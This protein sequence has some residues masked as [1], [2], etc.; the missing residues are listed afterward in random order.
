[1]T[2]T[3]RLLL[4]V[5]A[6]SGV[7]GLIFEVA[8]QR[9]L[10][11][12]FGVTAW[13]SATVLAAFMIG[14]T[15]GAVAVGNW[16]D[17][18]SNP[19]GLYAALEGG[20]GVVALVT[21]SAS[22][23]LIQ[24]FENL[25]SGR[26][27]SSIYVAGIRLLLALAF[28]LIPAFMMG[29]TF[30]ALASGIA[31]LVGNTGESG[32]RVAETYAANL[33]GAFLGAASATYLLLPSL[34]LSRTLWCGAALNFLAGAAALLFTRHATF[35][36]ATCREIRRAPG[37]FLAASAWSGF[38]TF[39]YEVAWTQLVAL[40]I[41][42]SAY[43]FGSMLASFLLG[44]TAGSILASRWREKTPSWVTIGV[45][46]LASSIAVVATLPLW[47]NAPV[48]FARIGPSI[49]GF[50]GREAVRV[51]VCL[52]VLCA[53]SIVLGM[54][55][56]VLLRGTAGESR[57][58]NTLGGMTAINTLGAA[59]GSLS[60]G[61][62]FLPV[63]GSRTLLELIS[64]AGC[65]VAVLCFRRQTRYQIAALAVAAAIF[66]VPSWD[67]IKI[68]SGANVYFSLPSWT[69][70]RILFA[71]ESVESGLTT[72][73]ELAPTGSGRKTLLTN[74]KFQGN[75]SGEIIAQAR[76]AQLPLLVDHNYQRALLIGI[77][78]ATSLAALA[79]EPYE[80]VEAAD[81]SRDIVDAARLHFADLNHHV[82]D[83]DRVRLRFSDGRNLLLLSTRQYDLVTIEISSIWIAGA[84]DL[85]NREFYRL[86]RNHLAPHGVM[87]QWV[88]LHH[89]TARNL[90]VILQTIRAEMPH[91]ALFAGGGQGEILASAAPLEINY[92]RVLQLNESLRA[93][94]ALQGIPGGDILF[95][96]GELRLDEHGVERFI[97]DHALD[98]GVPPELV[99]T[100]DNMYL[101]YETPKANILR[102]AS[103]KQILDHLAQFG[104]AT[105][106]VKHAER[107]GSEEH[108]LGAKLAGSGQLAD[109]LLTLNRAEGL[110]APSGGLRES[111]RKRQSELAAA[112]R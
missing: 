13:A 61:F 8:L 84:A 86:V 104:P 55:F 60:T 67:L 89:M 53:P 6:S 66:A 22:T 18:M 99:S 45:I 64:A 72:V 88:Q 54:F 100:D 47:G 44:L 23:R 68:S 83:S 15:L 37:L 21:P 81:L 87:Q 3:R 91:L 52:C 7:A 4:V 24:V 103:A 79:L 16:S 30:P 11:R 74:G 76:F 5:Y 57:V 96:Y 9:E 90:A 1:M 95:L 94:P 49:T 65:L 82:L 80:E 112:Q 93:T 56:P 40:V 110:G 2:S 43:A 85:Y 14:T 106:P 35:S 25:A 111:V 32:R 50:W 75:N 12:A 71:K 29:G 73:V 48:L 109:S 70:G 107:P 98:Q 46:Q 33:F 58:G 34:G 36:P 17:R 39:A 20:I 31:R 41:G 38:T 51:L 59:A 92:R 27:P 62:V 19:L 97:A 63:L 69:T 101:E 105:L 28:A 102:G 10:S 77:G 42:S 108:I 78:T 26:D